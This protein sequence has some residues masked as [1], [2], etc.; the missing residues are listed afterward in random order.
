MFIEPM[1]LEKRE[2][3]FDDE[4]YIFEPK[5]DGHRMIISLNK[6]KTQLFTRHRTDVTQQY[7]ELHNVPIEDNSGAVLDGEV[8]CIDP[9]TGSIDFELIQQRFMTR[10]PMAIMQAMVRQPVIFFAFD[11]LRYKGEDLRSKPLPE[12]KAILSRVLEENKHFSLVISIRGAG[13]SMF[14]AIKEKKL[15]GIVAKRIQSKYVGRKNGD[16]IKVINYSYADFH[17][18]GYRK[19]QF[20]WLL[21]EQGR[22]VGMIDLYVPPEHKKAFYGVSK[23]ILTGEDRNFVYVKPGIKA[24]VRFRNWYRS[25]MLRSPEFVEFVI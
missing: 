4:R 22:P 9:E 17:I 2:T 5:I 18:A 3:P 20:G 15:E 6:G 21:Q 1:L 25:G 14:N 13:I 16:W 24:R 8:A 12:R 10:K 23:S 7:P 11:I 19:N